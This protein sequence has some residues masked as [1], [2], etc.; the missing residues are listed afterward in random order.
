MNVTFLFV[1]LLMFMTC[2]NGSDWYLAV[3]QLFFKVFKYFHGLLYVTYHAYYFHI[4]LLASFAG[5]AHLCSF[6]CV[7][8]C[9]GSFN[10]GL[11]L[12]HLCWSSFIGVPLPAEVALFVVLVILLDLGLLMKLILLVIFPWSLNFLDFHCCVSS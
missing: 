5:G 10:N 4:L 11:L 12:F 8:C 7:G 9:L 2:P 3:F 1:F 6:E